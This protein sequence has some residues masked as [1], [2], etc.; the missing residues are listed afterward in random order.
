MY[1]ARRER[2]RGIAQIK[3]E[4]GG[5]GGKKEIEHNRKD[6]KKDVCRGYEGSLYNVLFYPFVKL[7][8]SIESRCGPK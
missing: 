4:G 5:R 2:G 6:Y 7:D 8:I 1:F 3:R